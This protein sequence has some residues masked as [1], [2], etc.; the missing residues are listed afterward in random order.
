MYV[1]GHGPF[2]G[3]DAPL[4]LKITVRPLVG[5]VNEP[6]TVDGSVSEMRTADRADGGEEPG[7]TEC[8]LILFSRFRNVPVYADVSRLS[9]VSLPRASLGTPRVDGLVIPCK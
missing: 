9:H 4:A 7:D 2:R 8:V 5:N 1:G 3:L 6:S